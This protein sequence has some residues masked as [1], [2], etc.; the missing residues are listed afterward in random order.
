MLKSYI[1]SI[2][3]I[4]CFKVHGGT[5]EED[6]SKAVVDTE[7]LAKHNQKINPKLYTILFFD[8]ANTTE[9]IG[10]IKE[11][12]CDRRFKGRKISDNVKFIAACNPYRKLVV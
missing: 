11:V 6:I 3:L 9:N 4:F 12:M 8:E 2:L 7:D 5:S 10:L 1:C